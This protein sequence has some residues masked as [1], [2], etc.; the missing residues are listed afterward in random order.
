[1]VGIAHPTA[2]WNP[3]HL[4]ALCEFRGWH[5][6]SLNLFHDLDA[7][8]R[9]RLAIRVLR[10]YQAQVTFRRFAQRRALRESGVS[11]ARACGDNANTERFDQLAFLGGDGMKA[12]HRIENFVAARA[13]A[14]A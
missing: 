2:A 7:L 13:Q 12:A 1:M 9:L 6:R 5:L 4:C 14:A 11:V 10:V 3:Y 8:P